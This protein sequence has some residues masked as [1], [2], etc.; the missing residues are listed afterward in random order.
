MRNQEVVHIV[1]CGIDVEKN[2]FRNMCR[3]C[4]SISSHVKEINKFSREGNVT[5][6]FDGICNYLF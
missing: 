6:T 5:D 2:T 3:Q 1:S 4:R